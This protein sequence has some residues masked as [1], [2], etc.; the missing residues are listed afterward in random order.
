M[1]LDRSAVVSVQRFE[2]EIVKKKMMYFVGAVEKSRDVAFAGMTQSMA[3]S[4]ADGMIGVMAV[5][6]NKKTAQKYAG[7]KFI[8]T[9]IEVEEEESNAR[10]KI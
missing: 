9:Q 8:V 7:K 1:G 3:M 5:F 6:R 4:W 2:G 10:N